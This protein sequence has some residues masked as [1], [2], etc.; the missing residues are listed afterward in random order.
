MNRLEAFALGCMILAGVIA[1]Y[2]MDGLDRRI[3]NLSNS[4]NALQNEMRTK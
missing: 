4:I 3:D 1:A 2:R